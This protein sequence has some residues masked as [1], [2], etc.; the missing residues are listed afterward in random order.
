MEVFSPAKVNLDLKILG[1]REDGFHEVDTILQTVSLFDRLVLETDLPGINL[2]APAFLPDGAGNLCY[3]AAEKFYG[4]TELPR[5]VTIT[6]E[7]NIPVEAGLGGGSSNAAYVLLG[8]NAIYGGLLD[9]ASLQRLAAELGSDVPFFLQGGTARA[10]G[11]GEQV[12]PLGDWPRCDFRIVKPPFGLSTKEVFARWKPIYAEDRSSRAND[13]EE[14]AIRLRPELGQL[15]SLLVA[16]GASQVIL[17]G[18]GSAMC[19]VYS[20]PPLPLA[21]LPQGYREYIVSTLTRD[22]C[23]LGL[24]GGRQS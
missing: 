1:K 17:C 12:V 15:R 3:Q 2:V 21:H 7:K 14:V 5:A 8:L 22:D 20:E 19:A 16:D 18:S 10:T 23:G 6:L 9:L 24:R 4:A 11:R 13:L